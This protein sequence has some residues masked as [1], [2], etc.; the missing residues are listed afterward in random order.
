MAMGLSVWNGN[1]IAF[2]KNF[3][4]IIKDDLK[5]PRN[6]VP[7]MTDAAPMRVHIFR[8]LNQSKFLPRG[9]QRF[10]PHAGHRAFPVQIVES[11]LVTSHGALCFKL[12][13]SN[14]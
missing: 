14:D 10:V 11:H 3:R 7:E 2:F 8:L 9:D 4:A 6:D 13:Q 5:A 1:P 12:A